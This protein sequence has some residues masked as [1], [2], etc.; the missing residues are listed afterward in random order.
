MRQLGYS[1]AENGHEDDAGGKSGQFGEKTEFFKK[2]SSSG[3]PF[4]FQPDDDEGEDV[5]EVNG[6]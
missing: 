5:L 6:V 2:Y 1:S 3:S 4:D